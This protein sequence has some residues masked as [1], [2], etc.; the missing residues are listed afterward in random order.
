MSTKPGQAH[1]ALL[2]YVFAV[3]DFAGMFLGY[4][5]TGVFWSPA[6]AAGIGTI[7]MKIAKKNEAQA[8]RAKKPAG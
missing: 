3:V 4:D 1:I 2:C 5:I 7:L 8:R 6:A